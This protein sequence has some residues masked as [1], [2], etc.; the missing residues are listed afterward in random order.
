MRYHNC[1]HWC[2]WWLVHFHYWWSESFREGLG[3][4]IVSLHF[5]SCPL[6]KRVRP[7][8]L[9]HIYET[10]HR[11]YGQVQLIID[12]RAPK[13]P[14]DTVGGRRSL[15]IINFWQRKIGIIFLVLFFFWWRWFHC[16]LSPPSSSSPGQQ[17]TWCFGI[18][19]I[20]CIYDMI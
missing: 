12:I 20:W 5:K 17:V 1:N 9:G 6:N 19:Y 8:P 7:A 16:W 10:H 13:Q 2:I 11:L 18:R 3:R 14:P 15:R 4:V